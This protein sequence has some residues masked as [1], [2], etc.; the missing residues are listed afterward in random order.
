MERVP[1]LCST[2]ARCDKS[3]LKAD[4]CGSSREV[5]RGRGRLPWPAQAH[6]E[7]VHQAMTDY[8]YHVLLAGERFS[9]KLAMSNRLGVALQG[10]KKTNPGLTRFFA[11][12]AATAVTPRRADEDRPH[13]LQP[14]RCEDRRPAGLPGHHR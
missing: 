3:L 1:I 2:L 6:N 8:A 7:A 9:H 4:E 12:A 10:L 14:R 11:D 5:D 13:R